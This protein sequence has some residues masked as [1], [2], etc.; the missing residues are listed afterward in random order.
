MMTR[1]I[2][3]R[4]EP[5]SPDDPRLI[6]WHVGPG[7]IR[8]TGE[9]SPDSAPAPLGRLFDDGILAA[10]DVAPGRIGTRLAAGRTAGDDG[11]AVRSALFEVLSAP[12]GWP[13]GDG[14]P[15]ADEAVVEA[16][17]RE[18]AAAVADVLAGDFGAYT[19]S[20]GGAVTLLGV[21]DGRV[22]VRLGGRCHGCAYADN[23]IRNDLAA[24][25]SAIPGFR[26]VVVAGDGECAPVT[27]S[28]RTRLSLPRIRRNLERNGG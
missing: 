23:T 22:R 20:H 28:T 2:L 4:P 8:T 18:I 21:T 6:S 15:G 24:R 25:L 12:G 11:P 13:G 17:D 19:A 27:K 1:P 16:A 26:G 3:L 14:A 5:A 9:I 7:L 10:V